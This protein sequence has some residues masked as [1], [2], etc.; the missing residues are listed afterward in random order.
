MRPNVKTVENAIDVGFV[1]LAWLVSKR[2]T[3]SYY[4]VCSY[5]E[6]NRKPN[7]L[8]SINDVLFDTK[9]L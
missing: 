6:N 8:E 2:V 1:A 7:K 4:T 5:L 9:I 3:I